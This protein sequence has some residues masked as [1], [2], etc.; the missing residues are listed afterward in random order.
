MSWAKTKSQLYGKCFNIFSNG[1]QTVRVIVFRWLKYG[2]RNRFLML[3]GLREALCPYM[4]TRLGIACF[5]FCHIVQCRKFTQKQIIEEMSKTRSS[6]LRRL[7]SHN[8]SPH[9]E[10]PAAEVGNRPE[11]RERDMRHEERHRSKSHSS[12]RARSRQCSRSSN[13]SPDRIT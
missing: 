5:V 13:G 8:R 6:A 10:D 2:A 7:E 1:P 12:R 3:G 11:S 4:V 9:V